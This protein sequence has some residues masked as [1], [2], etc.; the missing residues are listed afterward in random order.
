MKHIAHV[1]LKPSGAEIRIELNATDID[2]GLAQVFTKYPG[3]VLSAS[4][5]PEYSPRPIQG[6]INSR[7]VA[8]VSFDS[9]FGALV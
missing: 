3:R 2:D 7:A 5:R 1:T 9:A 6:C 8:A 4:C